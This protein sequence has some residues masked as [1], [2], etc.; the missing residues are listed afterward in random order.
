MAYFSFTKAAFD[1]RPIDVFNNGQLR[2]DFTYIDDVIESV[3]RLLNRPPENAAK[4]LDLRLR[5]PHI[6]YNVGNHS[7][8]EL[9][10][11]VATIEA[12]VGRKLQ[13]RNLPMQPGDV[14]ATFADVER[15]ARVAGFAPHT[16]LAEGIRLFVLWYRDYY[17][18]HSK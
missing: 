5:R 4:A 1:G 11:F 14:P 18:I 8:V 13:R 17:K 10:E 7:P 3:C 15:L 2:R 16:P 12:A 6:I 9:S